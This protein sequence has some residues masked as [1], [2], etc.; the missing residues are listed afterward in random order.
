M[1]K[2]AILLFTSLACFAG[3]AKAQTRCITDEVYA[4]MKAQDP[5]IAKYEAE[6]K[7]QI[8]ARLKGMDLSRFKTTAGFAF[9]DTVTY[10]IPI[11]FHIIHDYGIEYITDDAVYKAVD[12]I[13]ALYRKASADAAGIVYPYNGNIPGTNI[14][15]NHNTHIQFHLATIDPNG[16]PTH[17]ITRR[18]DF[19]SLSAGEHTKFDIWAPQSYLNVWVMRSFDAA[20]SGTSGGQVLAYAI[21]PA[22]AA[23]SPWSDGVLASV[24]AQGGN[25]NF[26]NTIAHELGHSLNL[27]HT[28][29]NTNNPGDCGDDGVDDTPPTKGHLT[30]GCTATTLS[31]TVCSRG[32]AT[33]YS[34]VEAK[35]LFDITTSNPIVINYPDTV[36]TQ[37]VMDYSHCSSQMFTYLQGVW[38]RAALTS[39]IADR[40]NLIDSTNL[41]KTGVMTPNGTLAARPD[42]KP[43]ADFSVSISNNN[44]LNFTCK[45]AVGQLVKFTER[46]WNDTLTA[47]PQWYFSNAATDPNPTGDAVSTKFDSAGWVTVKLVVKSN[48]G[49]DTLVNSDRVYIADE[50]AT[51]PEGYFGEFNQGGDLDEYPTFNYFKNFTRWEVVNNAGFYDNTSMS[52][53]QFDARTG[54][55]AIF[56]GTPRGDWDDFY[57]PAF[58][59]TALGN[60]NQYLTFFTA[61]AFRTQNIN[62]MNDTLDV[63]YSTDCGRT[64]IRLKNL[65]RAEIGNNGVQ[66]NDWTPG[67]MWNWQAQNI[68]IPTTVRTSNRVFFRF[69]YRPGVDMGLI[70]S[71]NNFYLDRI[72]IS[73]WTTD[74]SE[75]QSQKNGVV[76]APNPTNGSTSI[77][78]KDAKNTSANITVTDVTG[79]VVYRTQANLTGTISRVEIPASYISVK[80]M[81]MVEVVTGSIKQTQK[82]VVY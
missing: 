23:A 59:L 45:S 39:T 35:N 63:S 75:L 40:N 60:G 28:F 2:K 11:V 4:K 48:V 76:L 36:N 31:D 64:W 74:V 7:A 15:Y 18:R 32:Y 27:D 70:G 6:L 5:A 80:G 69:R 44:G 34:P 29:G 30:T 13:N 79:K 58:D 55:P 49:S 67:G 25:V 53:K 10:H 19:T 26:N 50:N 77:I 78:I 38:M 9:E 56:T 51:N 54:V 24:A 12:E 73:N 82:L 21:K 20:N 22:G 14:Q 47:D 41:V 16:N 37:N 8:D 72:H 81:Y 68:L 3:G 65:T 57:T 42:L 1:V 43:I 17:G 46:S 33:T 71:G 62:Y 61:G 66:L 52:Y